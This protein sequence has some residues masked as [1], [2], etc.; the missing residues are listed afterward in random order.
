MCG[1]VTLTRACMYVTLRIRSRTNAENRNVSS[2]HARV[3]YCKSDNVAMSLEPGNARASEFKRGG[4][5]SVYAA[6]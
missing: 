2:E 1:D 4:N 6:V 3:S 5:V